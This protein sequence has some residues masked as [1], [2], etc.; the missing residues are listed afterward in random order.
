MSLERK[1]RNIENKHNR[2]TSTNWQEADQ[3]AIYSVTEELN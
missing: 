3:L 2:L 1:E